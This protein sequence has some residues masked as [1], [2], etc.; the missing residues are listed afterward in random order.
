MQ[1]VRKGLRAGDIEKDTYERLR[2]VSCGE[3]LET[4]NDPDEVGRIRFCPEC[5]S[6]WK[7][8]G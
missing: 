7:K 3:H 8:I 4:R 2:C 6:E 1:S 5:G